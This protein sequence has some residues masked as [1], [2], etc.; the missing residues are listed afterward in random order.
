MIIIMVLALSA[1]AVYGQ[2]KQTAVE[3]C[4]KYAKTAYAYDG[5]MQLVQHSEISKKQ[6]KACGE[7][8]EIPPRPFLTCLFTAAMHSHVEP[9][10][11]RACGVAAAAYFPSFEY[12]IQYSAQDALLTSDDIIECGESAYTPRGFSSCLKAYTSY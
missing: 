2:T 6:V 5:C 3:L 4:S 9:K 7:V 1:G 12:C 10:R 11:I 8:S